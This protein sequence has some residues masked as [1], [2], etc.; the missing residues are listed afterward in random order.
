MPQRFSEGDIT[1]Q[2]GR[3]VLVT[4]ANSGLGLRTAIVLAGK[5]AHVLLGCRSAER[6]AQA[7]AEVRQRATGA[8]PRLI[9]LDL[10]SLDSV[11]AAATQVREFTEDTLHVLMNNAGVMA[12]PKGKTADG[13]ETQF[14]TNHL[15]H[16]ALTWLLMPALRKAGTAEAPARIVTVSSLAAT[17]GRIDADDPNFEGRRYDPA[18]AYGQ[19]KLANQVFAMELDR[20]LRE[21]GGHV[22]SV[23]AHPGYTATNLSGTMAGSYQNPLLSGALKAGAWFSD[24]V[25]AQDVRV[26]ALP[27]LYAATAPGVE[28]GQYFGPDGYRQFRGAPKPIR[29]LRP[30]RDPETRQRLWDITQQLTGIVPD[31][32]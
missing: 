26:G 12:V 20:R 4:G 7:L 29:P 14:G 1:D 16:A 19:A 5:G 18:S 21:E 30:A 24:K 3:T 2:H 8:E 11:R 32:K 27:Q 25:L 15:G 28:G 23:A 22:I 13:F 9:Q 10:A 6:G 17:R 31:P